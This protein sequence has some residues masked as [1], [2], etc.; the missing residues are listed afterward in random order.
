MPVQMILTADVNLMNVD[1]IGMMPGAS[2]A[3]SGVT[4]LRFRFVRHN[5]RNQTVPC[6]LAD[7]AAELGDII[8]RSTQWGTR[9]TRHG[10]EVEIEGL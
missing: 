2:I 10:D 3:G 4:R 5:D 9:L 7:E 6:A 8:E 1:R